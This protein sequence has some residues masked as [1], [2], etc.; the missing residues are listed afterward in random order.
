[1]VSVV[2][3]L[4]IN[5]LEFGCFVVFCLL[6]ALHRLKRF[7]TKVQELA[8]KHPLGLGGG[9]GLGFRGASLAVKKSKDFTE[10]I[11]V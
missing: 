1:M 11:L 7:I 8:A 2:P 5:S 6:Q 3:W 9:K 10:S 4:G